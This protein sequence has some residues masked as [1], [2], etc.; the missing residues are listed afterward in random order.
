[1]ISMYIYTCQKIELHACCKTLSVDME[2]WGICME[3]CDKAQKIDPIFFETQCGTFMRDVTEK[4]CS[5]TTAG[6]QNIG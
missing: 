4:C 2:C 6:G 3:G 1:M 5:N